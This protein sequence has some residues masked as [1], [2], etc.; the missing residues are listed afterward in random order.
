MSIKFLPL[1]LLMR[2]FFVSIYLTITMGCLKYFGLR[3]YPLNL[4]SNVGEGRS[5]LI[6]R[7]LFALIA[8]Y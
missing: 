6:I 2:F 5:I 7:Y 8:I 1:Q 3:L 4:P